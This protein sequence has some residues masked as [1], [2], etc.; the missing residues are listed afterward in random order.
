MSFGIAFENF[1]ADMI[2]AAAETSVASIDEVKF[3]D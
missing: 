2:S 3:H 1:S